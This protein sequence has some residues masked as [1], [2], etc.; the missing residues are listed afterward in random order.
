[1]WEN[2]KNEIRQLYN[3]E[4]YFKGLKKSFNLLKLIKNTK[5]F[6]MLYFCNFFI[7]IIY[8]QLENFEMAIKYAKIT[9]TFVEDTANRMK[10]NWLISWY[11]EKINIQ[12][13]VEYIDLAIE[14]C[15]IIESK[16]NLYGARVHKAFLINDSRM[17]IE[18]INKLKSIKMQSE[19][20]DEVY[21]DLFMIYIHTGDLIKAQYT[22]KN[23]NNIGLRNLL[24]NKIYKQSK[25]ANGF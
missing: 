22:L 25:A 5:D 20:M 6:D 17:A 8:H 21:Q 7:A 3:S 14:D 9:K 13:A 15:C 16:E 23:I 1:M 4:Q 24:L 11:Y 12:K 10:I 19:R 2:E 18:A